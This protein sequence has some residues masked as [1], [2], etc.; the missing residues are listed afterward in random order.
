M[1]EQRATEEGASALSSTG[2]PG[3]VA[4]GLWSLS[5]VGSTLVAS[6]WLAGSAPSYYE[7]YTELGVE[8]PLA[9]V[10]V[11]GLLSRGLVTILGS[12]AIGVFLA[13]LLVRS[14]LTSGTRGFL[15]ALILSAVCGVALT[16]W[17]MLEL[18]LHRVSSVMEEPSPASTQ[19]GGQGR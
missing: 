8:L 19:V 15:G 2:V 13:R 1:T 6:L 3:P 7:R 16:S 17:M 5:I 9:T 18:P 12:L 10:V 11:F 4:T 14:E